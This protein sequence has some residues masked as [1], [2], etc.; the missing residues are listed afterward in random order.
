M[1]SG[2]DNTHDQL[3]P[4]FL[5]KRNFNNC[6]TMLFQ[7]LHDY[8]VSALCQTQLTKMVCYEQSLTIASY[9]VF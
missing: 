5:G 1:F 6:Q 2:G 4:R 3:R 8:E 9:F 7:F